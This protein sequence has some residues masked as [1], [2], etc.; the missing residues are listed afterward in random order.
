MAHPQKEPLR[1][2]SA[3]EKA[4]LEQTVRARSERADRVNRARVLLAI[5][6]G[7]SF[8]QAGR[9]GGFRSGYGVAL[10]VR[11]FNQQGLP[12]VVGGHGGAPPIKY[13]V[14]ERE[15]ILNEFGRTPDREQDGTATWS[16]S[17]LQRALRKAPDGL[18]EV[19][20][21]T[22]LKVL[23]EGG[24]TF[25]ESRTWCQTGEAKRKR[26][27]GVVTVIDPQAEGKRGESSRR[28]P[29]GTP[30][31]EAWGLPLY[32]QDEAGPYQA[33]PHP[34][35][36]WQG[37]GE[38]ARQP[39]EYIRGGT[40]KLLTLFR[41]KSGELRAQ[42]VLAAP[43]AV[44]HPWLKEELSSLLAALPPVPDPEA[45]GRSWREWGW[46]EEALRPLV[47][48]DPLPPVRAVL[49]WDNLAGHKSPEMVQWLLRQGVAPLYTPV[50]GSWLNMA[51]SVQRIVVR[52]ALAGQ[53]PESAEEVM[54][55]LEASVIGWNR[56]PTAFEWGGKRAARRQRARER[57][58]RQGGSGAYTRRPVRRSR[59]ETSAANHNSH[60]K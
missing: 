3:A 22:L 5:A 34:G 39:H 59:L 14:P 33:I 51:E 45:P 19:S 53:H 15:R 26:K 47:G 41:P 1:A 2:L 60:G 6:A 23:H 48:E 30:Q 32:C 29:E 4:L 57:R 28:G 46:N 56:E 55:W 13:G 31:A 27:A 8:V 37:E 42:A 21:F 10:L 20:T 50:G 12:A 43:N 7:A 11:R 40:A 49:V 54:E 58:H 25:Q 9:A 17:T 52:R 36:S 38:P 16:L 35:P 44:L 24:Y 18:P